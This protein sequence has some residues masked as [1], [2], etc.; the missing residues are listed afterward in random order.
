MT[1]L[2]CY[3]SEEKLI[4]CTYH[5]SVDGVSEVVAIRCSPDPTP[6]TDAPTVCENCHSNVSESNT[7][8][9]TT[10]INRNDN[11]QYMPYLVI[12][13]IS[14]ST[15]CGLVVGY[16]VIVYVQRKKKKAKRYKTFL[17]LT[18]QYYTVTFLCTEVAKL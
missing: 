3:G 18:K 4:D 12:A 8:I 14:F 15:L 2:G 17:F 16:F 10:E 6:S 11:V 9:V 13:V 1:Q 7:P 5:D